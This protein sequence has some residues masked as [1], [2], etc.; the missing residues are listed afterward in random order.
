[1]TTNDGNDPGENFENEFADPELGSLDEN[2]T[3]PSAVGNLAEAWRTKPLF[4][5]TVLVVGIFAVGAA[6]I[7]FFGSA[8]SGTEVARMRR[9]PALNETP[10]GEASSYM[11]EQTEMAS[12]ER[13]QKALNTGG[14][15]FPTPIGQASDTSAPNALGKERDPLKELRAETDMLKKQV[16]MQQRSPRRAEAF[17]SSLAEAMQK[18]LVQLEASWQ[19]QG[20]KSVSGANLE[21]QGPGG[22]GGGS[23][24]SSGRRDL[25]DA[26]TGT[27]STRSAAAKP[28]ISPGTVNYAQMLTEANSDV[29]G[30]ILAQIVSGP[31]AGARAVGSFQVADGYEKYL[32]L[33]F[34]LADKNGKDYSINAI[35]L[36]PETTLGGIA[37]EVDERY[38]ARVV[39]PAAASFVQGVG[40]A[41]GEG[42]S[43]ITTNGTTTITTQA[44]AGFKRGMYNG[45]GSA[46]STVSNFF[47]QQANQTKPL[48]R[49]AAGT[50]FGMFFLSAVKSPNNA[51]VSAYEGA[52]LSQGG[53]N[54]VSYYGLGPQQ[55]PLSSQ[56]TNLY[57]SGYS[58]GQNSDN[59]PYVHQQ[60]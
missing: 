27:K 50:P 12:N 53:L 48:V 35:A 36:D 25:R 1:M 30:P 26:D 47:Q 13:I 20:M 52:E 43:S 41:M 5:F 24:A 11:R 22:T 40:Q 7:K 56:R 39:L 54:G 57:N 4:K 49:V 46:A 51:G 2:P 60:N 17:D 6:A 37:T 55:S 31:L 32:V 28:I 23:S 59:M 9:P 44:S 18:Q 10:G 3:Q 21:D 42:D 29:P 8:T 19:P 58:S 14:S 34:T 15:A 33:K 45:L 16:Q 38:F